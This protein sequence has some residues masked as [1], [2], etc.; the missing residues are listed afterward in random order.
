MSKKSG[1]KQAATLFLQKR[2]AALPK[3]LRVT[4]ADRDLQVQMLGQ[5]KVQGLEIT[6]AA[7]LL[8][9]PVCNTVSPLTLN[10][11]PRVYGWDP[12]TSMAQFVQDPSISAPTPLK[13][14][15]R[16]ICNIRRPE[17]KSRCIRGTSRVCKKSSPRAMAV[18][19][20]RTC[21]L[22]S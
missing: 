7:M 19:H 6:S 10:P 3:A 2:T 1:G 22:K 5:E 4:G 16:S 12:R 17:I 20:W 11:E 8:Y 15:I 9:R 13:A 14:L 21:H 18:A